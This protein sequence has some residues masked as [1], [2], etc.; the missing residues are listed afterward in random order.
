MWIN[1]KLE[2]Q[3]RRRREAEGAVVSYDSGAAVDAK[4]SKLH[5]ALPCAAP[6]GVYSVCP[7][8][9]TAL[10]LPLERG[11]AVLGVISGGSQGLEPGE[12]MLRSAG[13]ATLKLKND[14]TIEANGRVIG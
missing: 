10:V 13:G 12:I 5:S 4:G 7:K 9:E 6:Y 14:G 3:T 2:N 1:E 8:G 11:S